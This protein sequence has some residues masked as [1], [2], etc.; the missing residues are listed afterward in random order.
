M[1]RRATYQQTED[2]HNTF[3]GGV[4][5]HSN[6]EHTGRRTPTPRHPSSRCALQAPRFSILTGS[7][8]GQRGQTEVARWA[9]ELEAE[10]SGGCHGKFDVKE[11]IK[12]TRKQVLTGRLCRVL[13]NTHHT[14]WSRS[15]GL[16]KRLIDSV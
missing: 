10:Q 14:L 4:I 1:E 9:Q 7:R 12:N 8:K 15:G 5:T 6:K 16:L 11:N 2:V 3:G 13:T